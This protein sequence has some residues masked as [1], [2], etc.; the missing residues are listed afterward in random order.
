MRKLLIATDSFLPRWDG[1]ARFLIEIVPKLTG[2]FEI[3][4]IAPQFEGEGIAIE[5]VTIVR[6]PLYKF[7]IGDYTPPKF[8]AKKIR[9]LVAEHDIVWSQTIGPIG[10]T[11]IRLGRKANKTVLAYIHSIEWELVTKSIEAKHINRF[12]TGLLVKKVAKYFYNKCDLLLI[13]S[14][15]VA[16]LLR[17]QGI[18]TPKIVIRLGVN[19]ERFKPSSEKEILKEKLGFT[20]ESVIIGF[21]GRIGREKDLKTLYRAF[22]RLEKSYKQVNLLIV[23]T[24][25][26]TEEKMFSGSHRMKIVGPTNNIVPYLQAMDIFVLPSLTETSSLATME[27]MATGLAI[28]AT[29]VGSIQEYIRDRKNGL[30]FPKQNPY[31]L[32][33]K[34]EQLVKNPELRKTLGENARKTILENYTWDRTI[35]RIKEI[36]HSF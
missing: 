3:T 8:E 27:A 25:V 22:V 1:I 18:R 14:V 19:T 7:Q 35:E 2:D 12:M 31:V 17:L 28:I 36:L 23:G 26:K 5:G 11:A 33:L 9:E 32:S 15:D 16:R 13:P 29:P 10:M 24:G 4:I 34:L 6:L 30:T 20:K 21:S